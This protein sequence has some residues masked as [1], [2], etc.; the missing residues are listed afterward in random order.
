M[1]V[2][3]DLFAYLCLEAQQHRRDVDL[4]ALEPQVGSDPLTT[5]Q[6]SQMQE[7]RQQH[8]QQAAATRR[9]ADMRR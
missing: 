9:Q 7:A 8:H 2:Q 6:L 3:A 5:P 1:T 4:N